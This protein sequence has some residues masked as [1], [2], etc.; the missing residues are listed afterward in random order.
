M[1]N[2]VSVNKFIQGFIYFFLDAGKQV[3]FLDI[4][5]SLSNITTIST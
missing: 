1:L 2:T 5:L 3:Y 4:N